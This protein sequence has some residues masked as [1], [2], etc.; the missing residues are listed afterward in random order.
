MGNNKRNGRRVL[1]YASNH[2]RLHTSRARFR[3]SNQFPT[4]EDEIG[5]NR[6]FSA[7]K[8]A[9][10]F[11]EPA[12]GGCWGSWG[13]FGTMRAVLGAVRIRNRPAVAELRLITCRSTSSGKIA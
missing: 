13:P 1:L 7:N 4:T 8:L 5:F 12:V 10:S 11:I 9:F 2:E 6:I 3:Q